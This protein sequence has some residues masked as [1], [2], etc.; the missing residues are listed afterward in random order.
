MNFSTSGLQLCARGDRK[1]EEEEEIPQTSESPCPCPL[2]PSCPLIPPAHQCARTA[3]CFSSG[4]FRSRVH[5]GVFGG[6][7]RP[8]GGHWFSSRAQTCCGH[9]VRPFTFF[10]GPKE[11]CRPSVCGGGGDIIIITLN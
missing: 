1:E 5:Q 11:S 7:L 10:S 8:G 4:P 3:A 2:C 9:P 6:S